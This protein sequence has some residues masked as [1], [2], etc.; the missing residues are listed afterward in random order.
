[1]KAFF[2][3]IP[4]LL[5]LGVLSVSAISLLISNRLYTDQSKQAVVEKQYDAFKALG[6]IRLEYPEL[7]HL[8]ELEGDYYKMLELVKLACLDM[9][10]AE[11][12]KLK[13]QEHSVSM[14]IFSAFEHTLYQKQTALDHKQ[15]YRVKFL[16]EV[17]EYLTQRLLR[18]PRL[19]Y[20]WS[21]NGG[22]L[23]KYFESKTISYYET[24]VLHLN[25]IKVDLHGPFPRSMEKERGD[26]WVIEPIARLSPEERQNYWEKTHVV[27]QYETVWSM[28]DDFDVRQKIISSIRNIDPHSEVLIPGCGSKIKL[29]NDIAEMIPSVEAIVCTDFAKVVEFAQQFP[30]N[31]KIEYVACDSTLL[32]WESRFDIIIIVNSILS[33]SNEEN[34]QILDACW[35]SLKPGGKLIGFF[36]TIFAA[37]DIAYI[38]G[39]QQRLDRV[40]WKRSTLHEEKQ[41]LNQI[42]YTPLRLKHLFKK[43]NFVLSG[44]EIYFCDSEYFMRHSEG[45]Y[46]IR[47]DD[48]MIYE[49]F[50]HAEKPKF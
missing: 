6:K 22:N 32:P 38:E 12:S 18:N 48:L 25:H 3:S 34:R 31:T 24:K 2:D 39:N 47:D 13:L 50:V 4:D 49:H 20:M 44:M 21:E 45:Y 11:L 36:P 1:M 37:A 33:E 41:Q 15:D 29:Q 7:S 23:K 26:K 42:F 43:C 28:T 10:K 16:I 30:N 5:A 14:F 46:G 27:E 8:F 35:K 17:L 9:S 19:L 40:D